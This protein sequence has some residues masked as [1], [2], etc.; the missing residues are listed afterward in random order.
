MGAMSRLA[1]LRAL[2]KKR[3]KRTVGK[4]GTA[5]PEGEPVAK[6]KRRAKAAPGPFTR[7]E[8]RARRHAAGL[9]LYVLAEGKPD[10]P[11]WRI[12][13][14]RSGRCLLTYWPLSRRWF[15]FGEEG[16]CRG[17]RDALARAAEKAD[18]V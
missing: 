14:Q 17:F 3:F 7:L 10:D 2:D 15:A 5:A 8:G 4:A 18:G 12:Y 13:C 16:Q 6:V 11:T 1:V 9:G